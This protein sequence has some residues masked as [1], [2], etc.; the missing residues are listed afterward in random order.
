MV[1]QS[2]TDATTKGESGGVTPYVILSGLTAA[3]SGLVFGY[4]IGISGNVVGLLLR[5]RAWMDPKGNT[6]G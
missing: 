6:I 3:S 5:M 2:N 1:E 4:N